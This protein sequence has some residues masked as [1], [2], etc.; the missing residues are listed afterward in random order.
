MSNDKLLHNEHPFEVELGIGDKWA[1]TVNCV[2]TLDTDGELEALFVVQERGGKTYREEL[3]K[4]HS[5]P[6][7]R[8]MWLAAMEQLSR[9][10]LSEI[11]REISARNA[12]QRFAI[13]GER[14]R[15]GC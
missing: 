6:L 3:F 8:S 15:M 4:S 7:A 9:E 2:A 12:P 13:V 10:D 1:A 11:K 14:N 5:D